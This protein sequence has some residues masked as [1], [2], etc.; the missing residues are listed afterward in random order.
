M[1][2]RVLLVDHSRETLDAMG[3]VLS[4]AR[5]QCA[6]AQTARDALRLAGEFKPDVAVIDLE[7]PDTTG[8]ELIRML[9]ETHNSLRC[10]LITRFGHEESDAEALRLG[11][12]DCLV[13]PVT[14]GLLLAAVESVATGNGRNGG[15]DAALHAECHSVT[16]WADVIVRSLQA[17]RD[18]RTLPEFGRAV[19]VSSGGFRNWC[20]TAH[21]QPRESLKFARVLRAVIRQS[22]TPA[23]PE[24]LLN[25]VDRRT[26]AKLLVA[27]GG[28]TT[29][30][31]CNEREFLERQRFIDNQAALTAVKAAL[32][33]LRR[34]GQ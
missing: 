13:Q 21:L 28:T 26:L 5:H 7:V 22:T 31:P 15:E 19:G 8:P 25:V 23:P 6:R 11:A 14:P 2:H 10:L 9:L 24:D 17:P 16:R 30:L 1:A 33:S 3:L 4:R 18:F 12:S 20:R 32:V 27:S 34:P 29:R